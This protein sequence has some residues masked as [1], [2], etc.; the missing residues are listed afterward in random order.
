MEFVLWYN[1]TEKIMLRDEDIDELTY[2]MND[3]IPLKVQNMIC[4][5]IKGELYEED[6][7]DLANKSKNE[8]L[9]FLSRL[10]RKKSVSKT[11]V[12]S[13]FLGR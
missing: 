6:E 9:M 12:K 4:Y 3:I 13:C 11:K 8:Y 10:G 7:P 5:Y 1:P 2:E